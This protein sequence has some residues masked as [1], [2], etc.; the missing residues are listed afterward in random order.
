[1][2]VLFVCLSCAPHIPFGCL[3]SASQRECVRPCSSAILCT[4]AGRISAPGRPRLP[5]FP[6]RCSCCSTARSSLA[7]ARPPR[8]SALPASLP[9]APSLNRHLCC[10]VRSQASVAWECD[11]APYPAFGNGSACSRRCG[12]GPPVHLHPLRVIATALLMHSPPMLL[13]QFPAPFVYPFLCVLSSH[14]PFCHSVPRDS[15]CC[16]GSV[17]VLTARFASPGHHQILLGGTPW[18]NASGAASS[19]SFSAARLPDLVAWILLIFGLIFWRSF[20]LTLS[21]PHGY[22]RHCMLTVLSLRM[23]TVLHA[24]APGSFWLL[25]RLSPLSL[26][27]C[28][29][30]SCMFCPFGWGF[31]C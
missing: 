29:L 17:L 16:M 10:H 22:A 8:L 9:S 23:S 1:M 14:H 26:C 12:S 24:V 21:R 7:Q 2:C 28:V 4:S 25:F 31:C 11:L 18:W 20:L 27:C 3:S 6:C 19:I 13:L 5:A 15:L 30:G